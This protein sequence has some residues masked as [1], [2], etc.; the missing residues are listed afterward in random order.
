MYT[1]FPS[2]SRLQTL[3]HVASCHV[4]PPA[5]RARRHRHRRAQGR[6]WFASR[7]FACFE[8]VGLPQ[9][10]AP[11]RDREPTNVPPAEVASTR[12]SQ[13]RGTV[14]PTPA[15]SVVVPLPCYAFC[16]VRHPGNLHRP[17]F[18]LPSSLDPHHYEQPLG[19]MDGRVLRWP[20]GRE[21][22]RRFR[23]RVAEAGIGEGLP[24]HGG[25]ESLVGRVP[26]VG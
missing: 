6:R 21:V 19:R 23:T 15:R 12:P 16:S 26:S 11:F 13:L 24:E 5:P 2:T 4:Y 1:C 3:T 18:L 9:P 22:L 17:P 8:A 14:G 10:E 20:S 25:F 7:V